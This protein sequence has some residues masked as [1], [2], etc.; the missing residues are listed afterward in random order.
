MPGNQTEL[1]SRLEI[2]R[3]QFYQWH[4]V[5][6]LQMPEVKAKMD[7]LTRVLRLAGSDHNFIAE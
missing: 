3:R 2:S 5:E 1:T 7:E 4:L 6:K